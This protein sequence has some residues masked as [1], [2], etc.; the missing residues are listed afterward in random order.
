MYNDEL[1]NK[2][3]ELTIDASSKVGWPSYV[4][5]LVFDKDNADKKSF[6]KSDISYQVMFDILFN[7]K[8][9]IINDL[10]KKIKDICGNPKSIYELPNKLLHKIEKESMF[11][12][13]EE[14]YVVEYPNYYV[15][16][17]IGNNE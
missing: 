17:M 9:D 12:F 14:L 3:N 8:K 13:L 10:S 2:L 4:M 1:T 6:I 16:Y 11:Y 15:Y 7:S 5:T